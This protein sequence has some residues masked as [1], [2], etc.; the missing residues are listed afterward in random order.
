MAIDPATLDTETPRTLDGRD[1]PEH[2]R[3]YEGLDSEFLP[4]LEQVGPATF[5]DFVAHITD[6]SQRA[7]AQR[8]L[9][10]AE[11]RGLVEH[12]ENGVRGPRRLA[13][14]DRGRSRLTPA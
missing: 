7:D 5:D 10:S 4:I 11:W 8:W 6:G 12:W 1:Y 14:T 2:L 9:T 13:V 3:A